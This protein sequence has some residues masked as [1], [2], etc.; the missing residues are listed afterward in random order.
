MGGKKWVQW[1]WTRQRKTFGYRSLSTFEAWIIYQSAK[2]WADNAVYVS[3]K[4]QSPCLAIF[5]SNEVKK[6]ACK[7]ESVSVRD[8]LAQWHLAFRSK[9]YHNITPCSKCH[10]RGL[11][12]RRTEWQLPLNGKGDSRGLGGGAGFYIIFG[13]WQWARKNIQWGR[14]IAWPLTWNIIVQG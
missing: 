13:A 3:T 1:V 4:K 2:K 6:T 10:T 11:L 12:G 9:E 7:V 8:F 14:N 5:N